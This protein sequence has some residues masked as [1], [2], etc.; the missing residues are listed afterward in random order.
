MTDDPLALPALR[1][2]H[3]AALGM[4]SLAVAE[5]QARDEPQCVTIVDIGGVVI[6][7]LRMDGA[8]LNALAISQTKAR[9]CRAPARPAV[10]RAECEAVCLSGCLACRPPAVRRAVWPALRRPRAFRELWR[11][12]GHHLQGPWQSGRGTFVKPLGPTLLCTKY[13]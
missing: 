13:V 6:A 1:L 7:Q 5:A 4:V 11:S 10:R 8:R 2:R 12:R 3:E 9:T